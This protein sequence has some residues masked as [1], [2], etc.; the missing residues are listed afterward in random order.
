MAFGSGNRSFS[1]NAVLY[2][3]KMQSKD[4]PEPRFEVSKKGVDGKYAPLPAPDTYAKRVS[5]NLI[6]ASPKEHT[7]EGKVIRSIN[8]TLQDGDD[9]Y[10]VSVGETFLGRNLY[11]S[12][13]KLSAFD[14]IEI[15]LYQSKPKPGAVDKR[16]F[17]SVSLRQHNELVKGRYDHKTELPQTKK[18][19]VNGKDQTDTEDLDT[20]LREKMVAWCKVVNA[21]APKPAK[22]ASAPAA[23]S[24][25]A[26]DDAPE[27]HDEGGE[28]EPTGAPPF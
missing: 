15:G 6:S 22:Q 11:N 7:H 1:P 24:T 25:P 4:L 27:G 16:G 21:A 8:L 28:H 20:F 14:D 17:A 10:F 23:A 18:V 12:L 2:S 19:R 13:L 9:V 3:F 5:G 26:H